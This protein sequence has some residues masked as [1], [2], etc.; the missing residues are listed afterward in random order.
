MTLVSSFSSHDMDP[1]RSS[2]QG[3]ELLR[4]YLAFAASGGNELGEGVVTQHP[5][6]AFE[7]DVYTRLTSAGMPLTPQFGVGGYRIDFVASHP[8]YPGRMVLAIEADGG[9]ISRKCNGAR[10][11]SPTTTSP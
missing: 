5:M 8:E 10:S 1:N 7:L 4:H 11:R 9:V 6:D 3:V 2:A